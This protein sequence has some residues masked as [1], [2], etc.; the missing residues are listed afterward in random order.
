MQALV[1]GFGRAAIKALDAASQ[2]TI[3]EASKARSDSSDDWWKGVESTLN[4]V[5][6][7]AEEVSEYNSAETEANR[8]AALQISSLFEHAVLPSLKETGA[9]NHFT[10][11]GI[12]LRLPS[13]T[14]FLQGKAFV[15]ASQFA[16]ALPPEMA[17]GY[18]QAALEALE[19][20][21]TNVAVKISAVRAL[22]K[23]GFL[24]FAL[25]RR[26]RLSLASSV[27]CRSQP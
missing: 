8:P 10:L 1:D 19:S 17:E 14:P 7:V 3:A 27:Y 15:F 20:S 23:C 21:A 16:G 4:Q 22:A 11:F 26:S 18:V 6:A 12:L 25:F 24:W 9:L 13:A 5:G 2:Q